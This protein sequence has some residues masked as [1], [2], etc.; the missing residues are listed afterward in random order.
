[1]TLKF[2]QK[3]TAKI[4]TSFG[5]MQ[6]REKKKHRKVATVMSAMQFHFVQWFC[7]C[8]ILLFSTSD[9]FFK[10]NIHG[11]FEFVVIFDYAKEQTSVGETK[12]NKRTE[13]MFIFCLWFFEFFFFSAANAVNW[14]FQW[15]EAPLFRWISVPE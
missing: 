11:H 3:T 9:W 10:W 14:S 8:F 13:I 6:T 2:K 4:W 15:L 1:M 7:G 12:T 5:K